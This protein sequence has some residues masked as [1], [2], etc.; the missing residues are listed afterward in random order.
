[1]M[2]DHRIDIRN[3]APEIRRLHVDKR[4]GIEISY[5][6]V[7]NHLQVYVH[8]FHHGHVLGS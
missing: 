2:V 7:G 6:I 1:M 4:Y 5:V 8:K 3:L